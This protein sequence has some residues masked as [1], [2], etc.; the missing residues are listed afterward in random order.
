MIQFYRLACESRTI[1]GSLVQRKERKFPKLQMA[2]RIRQEPH[3][4]R[5]GW[6]SLLRHIVYDLTNQTASRDGVVKGLVAQSVRAT[7]S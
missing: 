3:L 5:D 6:Y 4:A 2:V 7:D 1:K